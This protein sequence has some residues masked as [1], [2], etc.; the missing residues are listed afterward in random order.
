MIIDNGIG[1]T[2]QVAIKKDF[3]DNFYLVK[4]HED[5]NNRLKFFA[6]LL[7]RILLIMMSLL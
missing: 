4:E 7:I 1:S 2:A 5:G 6:H 3:L